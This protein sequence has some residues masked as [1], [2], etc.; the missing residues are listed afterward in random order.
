MRRKSSPG[1]LKKGQGAVRSLVNLLR[2]AWIEYERDSA[3]YL[4]VAMIYYA[5]VSLIPLCLLL[6]ATL[7][8]L[9]RIS[10]V[11]G[12]VQEQMLFRIEAG[13]GTQLR[14]TIGQLLQTL[15][16]E[17]IV[18]T[19]VSLVGLLLAASV[20]FHHLRLTFRAIWKYQPPLVAGPVRVVVRTTILEKIISFVMVLSAGILL[21]VALLL[22]SATQWL[23]R[24]LGSLSLP[25]QI[26][27]LLSALS[28]L[29]LAAITFAVLLKFLPPVPLRWRDVWLATTLCSVAWLAA[30]EFFTLYGV[31]F[32]SSHGAYGVVGGLLAVML[33]MNTVSQVLFYGAELCKIVASGSTGG[34]ISRKEWL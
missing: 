14:V 16:Q 13:F 29:I 23:N 31:F 2:L 6:L 22:V 12:D 8:L 17:S 34:S 25:G 19:A 11:A 20:L 27:W 10:P 4:A 3:R 7:G 28:S 30:A 15:E 26:G 32:G 24:L 21:L 1:A 18:A 9:L 5:M 33:L